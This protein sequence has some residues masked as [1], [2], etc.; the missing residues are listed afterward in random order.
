MNDI[1]IDRPAANLGIFIVADNLR[2]NL[3]RDKIISNRTADLPET[4]NQHL[5]AFH[6]SHKSRSTAAAIFSTSFIS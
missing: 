1:K 3:I 6:I 4:D 5:E 2:H